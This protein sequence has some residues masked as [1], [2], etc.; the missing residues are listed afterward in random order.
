MMDRRILSRALDQLRD[1]WYLIKLCADS[2]PQPRQDV[3]PVI[4][5]FMHTLQAAAPQTVSLR[6]KM[7]FVQKYCLQWTTCVEDC[8]KMLVIGNEIMSQSLFDAISEAM[9][10]CAQDIP[11]V[12]VVV[13]EQ[14]GPLLENSKTAKSLGP[15]PLS[16]PQVKLG[17]ILVLV[18]LANLT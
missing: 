2:L 9:L 12:V 4:L 7:S 1:L 10:V 13:H 18:H 15:S 3:G 16:A 6:P 17:Q 5:K 8:V 14:L 11:E